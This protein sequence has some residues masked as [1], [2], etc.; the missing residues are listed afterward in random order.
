ME[1]LLLSDLTDKRFFEKI[2]GRD[3]YSANGKKIGKIWKIYISKR[4]RIPLKVVIK[5]NSGEKMGVDP[6]KL[7]IEKNKIML[8]SKPYTKISH[9]LARLDDIVENM[10][11]LKEE[12]F[13]LD[14]K[15]ILD[16]SITYGEYVLERKRIDR[17][18]INLL[19][20]A[21]NLVEILNSFVEKENLLIDVEERKKIYEILDVL[22]ND[23]IVL[24]TD[25]VINSM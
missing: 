5:K 20:E 4:T 7:R 9:I 16:S 21:K 8:F 1:G 10:K 14:E 18:R 2:V 24:P 23:L 6:E 25:L 12:L 13:V 22:E 19:L 11:R 17:E 15:F 3:V